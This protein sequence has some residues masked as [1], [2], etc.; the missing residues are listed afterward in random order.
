MSFRKKLSKVLSN[1]NIKELPDTKN[2]TSSIEL[3]DLDNLFISFNEESKRYKNLIY[4][5]EAERQLIAANLLLKITMLLKKKFDIDVHIG[6]QTYVEHGKEYGFLDLCIYDEIL[7][8]IQNIILILE[9]KR[10]IDDDGIGQLL[11]QLI[12]VNKKTNRKIYGFLTNINTWLLISYSQK[13][14]IEIFDKIDCSNI[15]SIDF[16]TFKFLMVTI[17]DIVVNYCNKNNI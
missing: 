15:N 17:V 1:L 4:L 11:S 9:L 2:Y 16:K 6:C 13:E 5:N 14:G 10:G 7:P 3:E 8:E 12:A